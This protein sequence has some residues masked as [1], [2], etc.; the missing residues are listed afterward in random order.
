[1]RTIWGILG[2]FLLLTSMAFAQ[3]M[4]IS[5]PASVSEY[6]PFTITTS[7]PPTDQFSSVQVAL[8]GKTLAIV[9]P[10]GQC[11]LQPDGIGF[12]SSCTTVD[13]EPASTAGLTLIASHVGLNKGTHSFAVSAI[14]SS[15]ETESLEIEASAFTNTEEIA[16]NQRDVEQRLV[17]A[18][19][20]VQTQA[21]TITDL[22]EKLEIA[23]NENADL[24][25][26]VNVL[27]SQVN[28][29]DDSLSALQDKTQIVEAEVGRAIKNPF[30]GNEAPAAATTAT[31]E[32]SPATG[33]SLT[34]NSSWIGLIVL[35]ALALGLFLFVSRKK[36]GVGSFIPSS[37]STPFFEGSMD[38]LF[39]GLPSG[40]KT[41]D[42][43][44]PQPKKWSSDVEGELREDLDRNP[45]EKDTKIHF[46]DLT[47]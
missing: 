5:G 19:A 31:T 33:F 1:M 20:T 16:A 9:Y 18:E 12:L 26:K 25:A 10:T 6:S 11:I 24:Y 30:A 13:K 47:R 8:D 41:D 34:G 21:T 4:S 23:Q 2:A 37:N 27:Q 3:T 43:S 28:E 45:P 46:S 15:G 32:G 17:N 38:S 39:K 36:G 40:P 14:G 35:V 44:D 7:L 42:K 29:Q 22:Q